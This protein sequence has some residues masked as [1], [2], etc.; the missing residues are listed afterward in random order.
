MTPLIG[1]LYL[2]VNLYAKN[3]FEI[4]LRPTKLGVFLK[5]I[6]KFKKR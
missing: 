1:L 3:T 5:C 2:K 4:N 6:S